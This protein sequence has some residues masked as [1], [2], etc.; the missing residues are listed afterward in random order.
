VLFALYVAAEMTLGVWA[1]S[2]LVV[3]RGYSAEVAAWG[4]ALYFGGIT[5]GRITTGFIVAQVGNRRCVHLGAWLALASA[6]G[7]AL[8]PTVPVALTSLGLLGLGFAP[9]YPCLMHEVPRRFQADAVQTVIGRQSGGAYVGAALV[10]AAAGALAGWS[11]NAI[12]WLVVVVVAALLVGVREL[13]RR[14]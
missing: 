13:D 5:V 11:L 2:T 4:T 10:P 3:A 8:A 12:P 6:V 9:L 14:S 7:F 1:G